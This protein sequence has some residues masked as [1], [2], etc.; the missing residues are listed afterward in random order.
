LLTV[1]SRF[2]NWIQR[3]AGSGGGRSLVLA[4][5]AVVAVATVAS[6]WQWTGRRERGH[7]DSIDPAMSSPGAADRSSGREGI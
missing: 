4:A 2:S 5:G 3:T 6:L 1:V 7:R